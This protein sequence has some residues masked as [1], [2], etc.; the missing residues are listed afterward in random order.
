M[1]DIFMDIALQWEDLDDKTRAYIA[2]TL[3]GTRQKNYFLA[4]M[5]D[6]KNISGVTGEAS[7][8]MELYE[9]AMNSAGSAA[10]KYAVYQESV[11]AA[12]DRMKASLDQLYSLFS[13]SFLKGFYNVMGGLADNI[14]SWFEP[15]KADY[16]G[17]ISALQA[18]SSEIENAIKRY[19][20]LD[21]AEISS[22]ERA[23]KQAAIVE[24]LAGKYRPLA[25]NLKNS[26]GAF[27]TGKDA[28]DEMTKSLK[29]N[30]EE[31]SKYLRYDLE[32]KIVDLSSLKTGKA[33]IDKAADDELI[34]DL[35]DQIAKHMG[36]DIESLTAQQANTIAYL[37]ET[38][39]NKML[40]GN[41]EFI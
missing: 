23:E 34:S 33:N 2:T 8:A 21:E 35:F 32:Q 37:V 41:D 27:L 22:T 13:S 28:V 6:M 7:R 1:S 25:E 4:L 24:T 10:E 29:E 40:F 18:E 20:E 9:G 16:S 3:A 15:P 11:T 19:K 17:I 30:N 5:E 39:K 36:Y 31:I 38:Y 26:E 12:H 14:Y